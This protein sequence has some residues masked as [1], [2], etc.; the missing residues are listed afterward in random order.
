M[1]NRG[2]YNAALHPKVQKGEMTQDQVFLEF[3]SNFA[4]KNKDGIVTREV[5]HTSKIKFKLI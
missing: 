1:I 5:F 2:I 3:L 4:D